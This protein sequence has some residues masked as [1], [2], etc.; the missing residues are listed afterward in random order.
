[1]RGANYELR[2]IKIENNPFFKPVTKNN[3]PQSRKERR[4]RFNLLFT[5]ERAVNK[6]LISFASFD[7][8]II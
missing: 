5:A 1:L 8:I 7:G 4:D 3:L 6:K 2:V